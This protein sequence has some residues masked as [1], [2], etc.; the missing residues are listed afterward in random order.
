[1]EIYVADEANANYLG[2]AP[3]EEIA[4]QIRASHGPSGPNVEYLTRLAKA[5]R[6]M[7]AEDEHV[8][9]LEAML[10]GRE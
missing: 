8:F 6:E 5:L 1:M 7:G 2:P 4:R 9:A 10:E 3:L